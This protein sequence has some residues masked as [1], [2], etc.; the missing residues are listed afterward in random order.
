M[1]QEGNFMGGAG[2]GEAVET[3]DPD[4]VVDSEAVLTDQG[5]ECSVALLERCSTALWAQSRDIVGG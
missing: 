4:G 1:N 2:I 5:G 3:V